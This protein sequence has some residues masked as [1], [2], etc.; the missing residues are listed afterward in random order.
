MHR[1]SFR[2]TIAFGE[3]EKSIGNRIGLRGI[4]P[5][6]FRGETG[7]WRRYRGRQAIMFFEDRGPGY[8]FRFRE[9]E[10]ILLPPPTSPSKPQQS[11]P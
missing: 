1:G 11:Y 9:V 6:L 3:E 10:F 8:V 4:G 7:Q 5:Y 2:T